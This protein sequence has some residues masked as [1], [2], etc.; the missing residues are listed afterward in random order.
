MWIVIP[1][2]NQRLQPGSPVPFNSIIGLKHQQTGRN[3]HSHKGHESPITKQQEGKWSIRFT[4]F[5]E[6]NNNGKITLQQPALNTQTMKTTGC[7][8]VI[9]FLPVMTIQDI[10]WLATKSV[11]GISQQ[12]NHSLATIFCWIMETKKSLAMKMDMKKII[13]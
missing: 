5:K 9:V 10:G 6:P 3:L 2:C 1:S 11:C 12:E 4:Y 7:Y 8:N 13:R